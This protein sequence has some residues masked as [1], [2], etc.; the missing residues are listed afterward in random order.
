MSNEVNDTFN[1]FA[2]IVKFDMKEQITF[3]LD[4][5]ADLDNNTQDKLWRKMS[6]RLDEFYEASMDRHIDNCD[7]CNLCAFELRRI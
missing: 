5:V 4:F 7:G 1:Q 3:L 2:G 6:N